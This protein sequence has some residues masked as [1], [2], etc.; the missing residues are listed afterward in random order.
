MAKMTFGV[1]GGDL[2]SAYAALYLTKQGYAVKTAGL[3]QANL[4]PAQLHSGERE[5]LT[6]DAVVLPLPLSDQGG[7]LFAPFSEKTIDVCSLIEKSRGDGILF[8]GRIP[9]KLADH[10][11]ACGRLFLDYYAQETLQL[12]NAIPT[13]EG[14]LALLMAELPITVQG[15]QVAVTGFG[16]TAQA[17]A[18]LLKAVGA[19][20]TVF[21]RK[22][23]AR[24]LA[25]TMGLCALPFGALENRDV[26]FDALVNTVP[27]PLL[28]G[29]VL[30]Q[31]NREC[32][33]I[34]IASAP[35]GFDV[36]AAE[37]LGF[38]ALRAPALPGR[39]APATAGEIIARTVLQML[40]ERGREV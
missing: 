34:D 7:A 18:R 9:Q 3:E 26:H 6:A 38:R 17:L 16:R 10:A 22:A 35:W 32:V 28:T 37:S 21:A 29:E 23:Q 8:G 14:T 36:G 12:R 13:A 33:L 4:L 40:E 19:C 20:V 39:A 2:R 31:L 27:A 24:T 5:V 1:M 25:E 30:G 15:A 11:A